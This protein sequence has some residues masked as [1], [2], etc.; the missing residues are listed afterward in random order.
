MSSLFGFWFFSLH[1]VPEQKQS[2]MRLFRRPK[3]SSI[4]TV[5]SQN[6]FSDL[7]RYSRRK[8]FN[9]WFNSNQ[10]FFFRP[11]ID[12]QLAPSDSAVFDLFDTYF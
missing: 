1:T 2:I 12:R 8:K 11:K 4:E 5:L 10:E 7:S 6:A 9:L 3:N